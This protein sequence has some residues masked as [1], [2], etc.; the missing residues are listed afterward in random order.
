MSKVGQ[1]LFAKTMS[2]SY[3][4]DLPITYQKQ[5]QMEYERQLYIAIAET[6]KYIKNITAKLTPSVEPKPVRKVRT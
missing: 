6:E 2:I 1:T 4:S 3:D 5:I